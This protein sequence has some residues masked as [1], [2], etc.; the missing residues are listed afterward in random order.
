MIHVRPV[1]DSWT[2]SQEL[3]EGV[4]T[5]RSPYTTKSKRERERERETDRETDRE[6]PS[7]HALP[8]APDSKGGGSR[9]PR[10]LTAR[11]RP[12]ETETEREREREREREGGRE[13]E[14]ASERASERGR[15]G[16]RE[17]EHSVCS[18]GGRSISQLP[19]EPK[20]ISACL[21]AHSQPLPS[22][23]T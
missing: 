6:R 22:N 3:G 4:V 9:A 7:L 12:T 19:G 23:S 17:G 15:E 1:F 10:A 11:E 8:K 21:W 5:V 20:A 14:R 13:S 16:G 2:A 18:V